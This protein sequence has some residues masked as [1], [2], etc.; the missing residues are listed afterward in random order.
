MLKKKELGKLYD[1]NAL[2]GRIVK[3]ICWSFKSAQFTFV[4]IHPSVVNTL[5][6][7]LLRYFCA[8]VIRWTFRIYNH[9]V[10]SKFTTRYANF[11]ARLYSIFWCGRTELKKIEDEVI[12]KPSLVLSILDAVFTVSP[13][14][15]YRGILLPITPATQGPIQCKKATLHWSRQNSLKNMYQFE[16]QQKEY[17]IIVPAWNCQE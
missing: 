11:G 14:K 15:Q 6:S 16:F 1:A 12:N 4:M 7:I 17:I 9:P 10:N 3:Y 8:I 2:F 5:I 13:N